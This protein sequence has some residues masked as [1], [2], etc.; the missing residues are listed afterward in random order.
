MLRGSRTAKTCPKVVDVL[1]ILLVLDRLLKLVWLKTLKASP[2]SC[3]RAFSPRLMFLNREK[4]TRFVGGPLMTPRPALPTTFGKGG[5][6]GFCWTQ[7]VL[8]HCSNVCGAP[9]FGSHSR[10]GRLPAM[11]AGTLPSPAA[12][13]L[14]VGVYPRPLCRVMTPVTSQPPRTFPARSCRF[15]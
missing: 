10:F 14:V 7:E 8:N 2:R 11:M 15:W 12:S 1:L 6:V 13:K 4:S 5:A 3:R 9:W